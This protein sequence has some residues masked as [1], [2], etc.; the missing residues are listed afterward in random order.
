MEQNSKTALKVSAQGQLTRT[1][2]LTN[3][4]DSWRMNE[5][6][7]PWEETLREHA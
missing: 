1:E 7:V 5:A 6:I 2:C 3:I 4:H